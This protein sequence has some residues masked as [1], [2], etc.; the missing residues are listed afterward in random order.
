MGNDT[1]GKSYGSHRILVDWAEGTVTWNTPGSTAGT[2]FVSTTTETV[3]VTATGSYNWNVTSDVA[4]FVSGNATNYGW[5]VIWSSNTSGTNKRVDFG[6]K[7]NITSDNRPVLSVTYTSSDTTAPAVVSDLALS[8]PSDSAITVSWTAPG[9]DGSTGTA[10]SYDLRY[11]TSAI[12]FG[13]FDSATTVTGEPT[14]SVAGTSE[15]KVVSGLSAE[16]TYYFAL[17]T[18]DEVPNISDISNVPGLATTVAGSGGEE[19]GEGGDVGESGG[20]G[21]PRRAVFSGQAY[22]ES[23]IEILRRSMLG[24]IYVQSPEENFNIDA[25]GSFTFSYT[26]LIGD[27][28]FFALR[29]KDKDGQST[30][31]VAFNAPLQGDLFE[32]KNI[33]VS[34]TV[35]FNKSAL[36]KND[37]L[38]V[39]GYADPNYMIELLLDGSRRE[40]VKAD[41]SGYWSSDIDITYLSYGE[42]TVRVRQISPDGGT[43][44][45]FSPTRIF[46]ILQLIIPETDLNGD[47][48]VDIRDWSIFIFRWGSEDMSLRIKNDLNNDGEINVFDFSIF[49]QSIKI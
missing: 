38:K 28:Y 15:S 27:D 36:S 4:D 40:D 45:S 18:S 25:H 33:L 41:S 12:T 29:A 14:P 13:N 23:K 44:S 48:V 7:E 3:T 49:L 32:A 20:G 10:T 37:V 17:K 19:S 43:V 21:T 1:V 22:P 39:H 8:S 46:K 16:T 42:H 9:D 35:S 11:S 5:R 24:E 34:P 30:G 26:G 47:G 6:T 31:I 2:H